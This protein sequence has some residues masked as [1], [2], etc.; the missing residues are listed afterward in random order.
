MLVKEVM[1]RDVKTI[2]PGD[3]VLDAAQ[4]MKE[5]GVGCLVVIKE[6]KLVGILTDSD[7]LGKVVAEDR[8][9]SKVSVRDVMSKDLVLIEEDRDISDAADL[10]ESSKVKKLPVV[11]GN[12]LVG[13]LTVSDLAMAQPKLIK[14]VSALMV[15]PK[16]SKNMAG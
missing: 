6:T 9:A 5:F 2:G 13:I 1:N 10:M 11:S 16:S 15:L 14:Q 3:T 8:L 12:R 7:I 4:G